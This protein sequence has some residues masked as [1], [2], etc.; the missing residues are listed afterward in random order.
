MAVLL[1][2]TTIGGHVAVHAN[3]IST[4]AL[5][6]V[7]SNVITTSG[8]TMTGTLA[9]HEGAYYGTI[10][11]G[12]NAYWRAG[13]SQRDA[14]NAELRIWAKGGGAG[15]IYFATNFDGESS[16]TTLPSDGMAL[17]NNNLGI[18]GW[19]VNEFPSYK[20]HVKGTGYST[21]DFR[22]PIFYDSA[23]TG[24]Y[25]DPNS[26]S[27]LY[28][29]VL[30]GNSYFRPNTWIQFD[31]NYGV[32]WPNHYGLHIYP[33]NDGS[34]GSLQ[35][36]GSKNSWHGI[37]FD[38]GSTLMMNSGETG[39]HRQG[40][41]WQWRW[42]SGEMYISAGSTGGGTERTVIHSGNIG[43]QSV[44][45]AS[46]AGSTGS[47]S[48][49]G[50][51]V[52]SASTN[53]RDFYQGIQTSFVSANEGYPEYGSVVRVHTY[54]NDGG[55]AELYFPY[56]NQYGGS[57]MR[58]RLGLYSNAGWTGWKTVIDS[59]N[60]GSQSVNY[61]VTSGTSSATTQTNFSSLTVGGLD[62]ATREYVTSQG[63]LTSLP[64]HTHTIA[65]VTGL[66]D[67]LDGKQAAG[68]YAAS[69]HTHDDRYYTES[70]SDN[71][72]VRKD[73]TGQYLK[74]YN[75]YTSNLP[76]SSVA[77]SIVSQ[78][79]GGGLRV[80]FLNG[81]SFGTWAH[82]ITFSGYNGYNMYQ[83]AGHYKG[84]GGEGPDLYVRCEPNHSQNSW[85]SWEK[86]W[87]TGN[88]GS[89]SGLDADLLD[90]N[91]A[92]A[93]AL[94]SHTHGASSITSGTF[95]AG[96]YIFPYQSG[97]T[98]ASAPSYTQGAIEI[99]TDSNHV[100]AIGFHRGGHSATTLYEYDGQLYVN[101]W[102]T[103]AQTG[104]LLSTGN[105]GSYAAAVSHTHTIANVTGLQAALD[106]KQASGS[107]LTGNQ[108]ITLSGD[109]SGSGAT[110][111][112]VTVDS[113]DGWGFVNTGSNSGT[114]ADTIN[115]N[116]ISYYTGGVT[117]FSGNSTD[118]ALYS[119]RYSDSWQHQI[120]GDYR[121][122]MIAVRGKNNGTWTS[123]R[124]II[125]SSTIGSQSVNY[126]S[127]AGNADTT[128]GL[129]VHGGRNNEADKIVRTDSNGYIQAGWIN[130]T[131]GDE[132]TGTPDKFYGS[133]DNY[134]RYY[135]RA[136]TQMYLGLT[137]KYTT[138]R[139]Q[140]TTD[141]NYWTG[142]MGYGTTDWND[143]FHWG[144]GFL[145][146]WSNP[147]N[148]P[149]S[150]DSHHT[151][152]Q[153]LHYTNGS[154]AAYGWQMAGA[155]SYNELW[156]RHRW[157][158]S[159]SSWR[160]LID[161]NNIGSQSVNYAVTSGT[162]G[163]TTQTNF[164][165]LTI[166]GLDVAT[167]EYVTSQ[168]YLQSLPAHNHDDR[169]YT[170]TE[171][172]SLLAGK[173]NTSGKAAD[174]ETVDGIDSSRIIYG[175]GGFGSTSWSDMNDTAQKSGFFFYYN[176]TGNPFGDWTH[177]INSMGNSW[178]PNY[179]FQLA[180]AFH[181][182]RFA[183]RVVANGGFG[184]WRT[185]IDSG[186]I[187][188]Q[189]VSYASTAGSASS[190]TTA[191][192]ANRLDNYGVNYGSDWNTWG[193]YGKLVASS[194]HD[195]SGAN[196]P[197]TYT[198]GSFLSFLN[199][200]ADSFQIA[201]PENQVNGTGKERAMHFR[202]AW[203]GTWSSWRQVVD[204]QNNV[205]DILA[206]GTSTL[207]VRQGVGYNQPFSSNIEIHGTVDDWAYGRFRFRVQNEAGTEPVYGAQ[208]RIERFSVNTGWQL[209]GMV[210]RNSQN[211][212]WQGDILPGLS[213]QRVKENVATLT[214][215]VA[216]VQQINPVEFDWK[217]VE[218]VSEREGHDIGFIAQQLEE[219]VPTAVHTRSDG[220][221][222]VKYE[223]VVPILVQAIKEQQSM[224]ELLSAR[225]DA[226]EQK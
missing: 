34:Y 115:S 144:S 139:R 194:Y 42:S 15:S 173:L 218:N 196:K 201:I 111:I 132:S 78:M 88:D 75:E 124:T 68:S 63:Y 29:L 180:H 160:K 114:N 39:V 224:I 80:D 131:S 25:L 69:S 159:F 18:G 14:G 152:L 52:W 208:F 221:K 53:G 209:L 135:T 86:L 193:V 182:D 54:P 157:G 134:I 211:L 38:S 178:N 126:A 120:A 87:H 207:I 93:F 153:V 122:G 101:A 127:G 77:S 118:G 116:G 171:V 186:N 110:S 112:S 145:D 189:S 94:S 61:A 141:S 100:P 81:A 57:S 138:S 225:L 212:E 165:S 60:I 49:L 85:S 202:S 119:Q 199:S 65:N 156:H 84:S 166:G 41:G 197:P 13:I 113:I 214:D 10:T 191:T 32:Y 108:T 102:T 73:T 95:G 20:L 83:L 192:S 99:Y 204:I 91:H 17:K 96:H 62:V 158:G 210:P 56:S 205:C 149:P 163:A 217:P 172:N 184:S 67:A 123:W 179:G 59:D 146:S 177:W 168:N 195:A 147:G 200:G 215:G 92:S 76:A 187:G 19:G 220:Y 21:S 5:T 98:G 129:H 164:A 143:M 216:I 35:V 148:Q 125:D 223:K 150:G 51:Y 45:Y 9:M 6:S 24:Y 181:S 140:H 47:L 203:N 11:F 72:F 222:T 137:Y 28:H 46:S 71:R 155:P 23:D 16:A 2:G 79:G 161:S 89:G 106:G 104:L 31:G 121:S 105:I 82:A 136:Y 103:R 27:Y 133:N 55:S 30:S 7:P 70:E 58:Y 162:S 117:N 97:I 66:Q 167:R 213:D 37:H 1:S 190:A 8:G 3:N 174:S 154:S 188:S 169:Y 90:G 128:D 107:Y 50:S 183:V 185:I 130:T 206:D 142:V 40:V 151:G 12:S 226:L 36:K 176:P 43:S 109:V 175:D 22:A 64:S 219:I 33:N 26:T 4:Y 48:S 44:S 170:E 74:P 198:Y